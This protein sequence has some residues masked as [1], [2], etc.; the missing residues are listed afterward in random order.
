MTDRDR[1]AAIAKLANEVGRL[2][3]IVGKFVYEREPHAAQYIDQ[4]VAELA[5]ITREFTQ[6][7]PPHET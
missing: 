6:P 4:R 5:A 3:L 7:E 1:D 2:A